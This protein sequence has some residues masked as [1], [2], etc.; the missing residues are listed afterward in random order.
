MDTVNALSFLLIGFAAITVVFRNQSRLNG[1]ITFLLVLGA[2]LL[3]VK[4]VSPI[5]QSGKITW[6]IMAYVALN[7]ALSRIE[8]LKTKKWSY[9]IPIVS[10]FSLL[11]IGNSTATYSEYDFSFNQLPIL[12]LPVLGALILPM[13]QMK[14]TLIGKWFSINDTSGL[15]KSVVILLIGLS[16]FIGMFF[17]S[18]FG[19]FLITIGFSA[20]L[21][22]QKKNTY[23]PALIS[24]LSISLIH[25]F[26]QYIPTEIVDLSLGKTLEGLCIGA[27]SV[28]FVNE[29]FK[30]TKIGLTLVSIFLSTGLIAGI[31][32]LATQKADFGGMDAFIGVLVGSALIRMALNEFALSSALFALTVAVGL[33]G[34]PK[35]INQEEQAATTIEVNT[36]KTSST[37]EVKLVSPFEMKGMDL[38][39]IKGNYR[40]DEKSVQLNFQLGPKGGVTKG[41]FKSF[42]G[43]IS[44][45]PTLENSTFEINLPVNQLSTFNSMR[46]ESLMA[47]EYF[48]LEKFPTMT[49]VSKK[50]VVNGDV[51]E[52]IGKFT[53]LGMTKEIKVKLKYVGNNNTS[54]QPILVGKSSLDRTQFGMKPDS[55]EG[56]IVDFEFKIEL[57]K[58]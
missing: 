15:E 11:F 29:V 40:L 37:E 45:P 48:D 19:L 24:L 51:Y 52:L 13:S 50:L 46:D 26:I 39:L 28:Y 43:N 41:A 47:K 7:F 44:I 10:A 30:T 16:A 53:M 27:F 58:N 23:E 57:I 20:Q 4:H 1:I 5:E 12:L 8:S 33:I 21:F 25:Y 6:I 36:G 35:S 56:N 49:Y 32:W 42:T 22:F 18:G 9:L 54:G 3:V 14:T 38:S 34:G 31:L 55:K 2:T 17:A